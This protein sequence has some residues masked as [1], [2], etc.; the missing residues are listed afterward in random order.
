MASN[1]ARMRAW[2]ILS[3]RG[4]AA[5][6]DVVNDLRGLLIDCEDVYPGIDLWL[7]HKALPGV[8]DGSRCGFVVYE[9]RKPIAA[10]L[11]KLVEDL[12]LCSLRVLPSHQDQG[13]GTAL[14]YSAARVVVEV[15]ERF[16][17]TAPERLVTQRAAFFEALGF[18][19]IE[20]TSLRY[21]PG[22]SE[23]LY[24]ARAADVLTRTKSRA[25][26]GLFGAHF[27]SDVVLLSLYP[28]H[29]HAILRGTK[30][31]ELRKGFCT[32]QA[33][34]TIFLYASAPEQRVLG[35][36]TVRSVRRLT[37]DRLV[38]DVLARAGCTELELREYAG[39]HEALDAIEVENVREFERPLDRRE[40]ERR[41]GVALPAPQTPRRLAP[42]DPWFMALT[43][44]LED[45]GGS[46]PET[47]RW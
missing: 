7:D 35:T 2:Q 22:E 41:L 17:F 37:L 36:A 23:W 3:V 38:E 39:P 19:S 18:E 42:S 34:A 30:T 25:S 5:D 15:G 13:V 27:S 16:H 11:V 44:F 45:E 31:V 43:A 21:R 9:G 46:G 32:A 26:P 12:K 6:G 14:F 33:G 20:K 40:A 10:A 24:A 28:R 1:E 8:H 47:S 29:A 4:P